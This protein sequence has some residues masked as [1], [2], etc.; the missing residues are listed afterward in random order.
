M[1]NVKTQSEYLAYQKRVAEFQRTYALSHLST[2]D[3]NHFSWQACECC[4]DADGG[5]RYNLYAHQQGNSE[6]VTFSICSDCVYYI[7]YGRLDDATML[8][9]AD[10]IIRP[11][12]PGKFSTILDSYVYSVSLD[13]GT[14]E[15]KG[16]SDMG[17]GWHRIMRNGGT[18][19]RDH[20]PLLESL[21]PAEQEKLTGCAG[22]I[23]TENSQGFV[24]V[25]YYDTSE[26]L[27][28]AW[29]AIP[30]PDDE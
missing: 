20:D 12:G 29:S 9:I 30:D 8:A 23:I 16:S 5:D 11:Y 14:D 18:I 17:D 28:S 19:F 4:G 13:G 25:D 3:Q 6:S 26:S 10:T 1:A 22:V 15:E 2:G 7:N 21:N 27:E 24:Y